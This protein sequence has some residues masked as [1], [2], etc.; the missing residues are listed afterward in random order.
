MNIREISKTT[1]LAAAIVGAPAAI[2]D[3]NAKKPLSESEAHQQGKAQISESNQTH[4][5]ARKPKQ[6][7]AFEV[8]SVILTD[9]AQDQLDA[10]AH[11]LDRGTP[12]KVTIEVERERGSTH[13]DEHA[14]IEDST[15]AMSGAQSS[16]DE[17]LA[18]S[19]GANQTVGTE[20]AD[21]GP[22]ELDAESRLN[23]EIRENER[24]ISVHRAERVRQFLEDRGVEVTEL[25]VETTEQ[26]TPA[27]SA[28]SGQQSD[29]DVQEIH[30]VIT[31]SGSRESLTKR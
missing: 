24:L 23:E 29:K 15:A 3:N 10:L 5:E 4:S 8:D 20:E 2:A 22:L 21:Y 27:E 17:N 26:Q 31:E 14:A 30:I 28:A 12:A 19:S 9:D 11:S 7:V 13:P 6:R 18:D 16:V 25:I 1:I